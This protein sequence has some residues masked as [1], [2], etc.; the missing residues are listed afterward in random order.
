MK[1]VFLFILILLKFNVNAQI[2]LNHIYDTAST[3]SSLFLPNQLMIVNFEIS[4][5]KYVKINRNL[6]EIQIYSMSHSL[7]KVISYASFPQACNAVPNILYLSEQLF[8]TDNAIEF[9]YVITDCPGVTKTYIYKEDGTLLFSDIASPSILLNFEQ[10][11]YPIYNTNQGTKMILSYSNGQAKVFNLPG[12]LLCNNPCNNSLTTGI[13]SSEIKNNILLSNPHP[14][15]AISST[16][17]DYTLPENV[18]KGEIV[19]YDV[20]GVEIK[21]F[22]VDK[23]FSSLLISTNDIAAGTYYYQLQIIGTVAAAKKLVIIK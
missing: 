14:N 23:T 4:G 17:I 21:R 22:S 6:D 11:Q 2:T 9:M 1:K 20:R 16:T 5:Y 12:S 3:N 19:F 10:Q 13:N 15:P 18:Q 7:I 8:D